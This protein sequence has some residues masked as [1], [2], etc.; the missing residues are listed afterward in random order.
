MCF[1][2]EGC[3]GVARSRPGKS[4]ESEPKDGEKAAT[5]AYVASL[6]ANLAALARKQKLDTLEYLL[7]MAR[8]EAE[9]LAE[10]LAQGGNG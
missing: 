6:V 5:A 7:D 9:G 10:S 4:A 2:S 8:L 1:I 3:G